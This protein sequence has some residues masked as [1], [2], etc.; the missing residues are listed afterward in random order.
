MTGGKVSTGR[1]SGFERRNPSAI[2]G[3]RNGRIMT[4]RVNGTGNGFVS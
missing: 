1:S 2:N 4:A 3:S